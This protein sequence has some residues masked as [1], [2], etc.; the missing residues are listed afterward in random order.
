MNVCIIIRC[1]GSENIVFN[2]VIHFY[3]PGPRISVFS[4]WIITVIYMVQYSLYVMSQEKQRCFT[5]SPVTVQY[6]LCTVT[7]E[8][9]K[10]LKQR[11]F[12]S[13]SVRSGPWTAAGPLRHLL[14]VQALRQRRALYVISCA[15]R[16]NDSGGPF[17]SSPVRCGP[18]TCSGLSVICTCATVKN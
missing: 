11:C 2:I 7:G 1:D 3:F 16:P 10:S 12:T 6:S 13:F 18:A 9:V 8:A 15:F 4:L 17:T 5:S 14:C